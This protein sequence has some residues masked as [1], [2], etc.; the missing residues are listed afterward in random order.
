MTKQQ[1]I[2]EYNKKYPTYHITGITK[3]T[4]D[5]MDDDT[6]LAVDM[7]NQIRDWVD[8]MQQE[9]DKEQIDLVELSEIERVYEITKEQE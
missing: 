8:Y 1:R 2:D 3:M 9:L 6:P 7:L 4:K 5:Q